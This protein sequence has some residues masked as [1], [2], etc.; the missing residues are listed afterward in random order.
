MCLKH[1]EVYTCSHRD[2]I[3]IYTCG[4]RCT[5]I[6]HIDYIGTNC[7]DCAEA[8]LAEA[9]RKLEEEKNTLALVERDRRGV[10]EE[11]Y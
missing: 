2:C 3:G 4:N 6:T 9:S 8:D 7:V 1:Y 11:S 10:L 5:P